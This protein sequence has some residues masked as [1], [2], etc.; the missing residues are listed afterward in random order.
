MNVWTATVG[1]DG[2]DRF[3]I[4]RKSGGALGAPFAPSKE[5]FDAA[6]ALRKRIE[7]RQV[8]SERPLTEVVRD[9]W[10]QYRSQYIQ[11]MRASFR[12][13]PEK[14]QQLLTKEELTLV[15]YCRVPSR[16]HR[17][18]LAAELLPKLG[19]IYLGER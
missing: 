4:T 9:A 16:C 7:N 14:W 17:I 5:S 18:I 19:A 12:R 3:D 2:A 13:N 8:S 1:Y 10:L 11:H 6:I 15:C